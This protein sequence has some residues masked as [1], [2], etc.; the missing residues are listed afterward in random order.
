MMRAAPSGSKIVGIQARRSIAACGVVVCHMTGFATKY[1]AAPS[2]LPSSFRFGMVGVDLF[3]R[4]ERLYHDRYEPGK[5][6]TPRRSGPASY[7]P[8]SADL[9]DLLGMFGA[10]SDVVSY[11]RT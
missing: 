1:L 4:A 5:V 6:P 7:P 2:I 8:F 11:T 10:R 3:I 9:S